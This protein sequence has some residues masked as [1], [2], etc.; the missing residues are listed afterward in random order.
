MLP[1]PLRHLPL[2]A[3]ALALGACGENPADKLLGGGAPPPAPTAP[4]LVVPASGAYTGA[5]IAGDEEAVTEDNVSLENI[6]EFESGV[7]KH[8]AIIAFS[9][10][11]GEQSFPAE[12]IH[13][14]SAHGSVP[15]IFWSPWDR[16]YLETKGPDRFRLDAILAGRWDDYI[17]RWADAAREHG[18]PLLVSF[19]NEMNGNWFPWSGSLYGAGEKLET[20]AG[21]YAGP[22]LFKQT[23]R[24]VVDRVRA[25]GAHNVQWVF[26]L[27]NFS[28]PVEP[29]NT[30]ANYYPGK[31]YVD[32][33]GLSVYGQQFPDGEWKDFDSMLKPGYDELAKV[34]PDKPMMVTEWGVGEFPRR[35]NAKRSGGDKARW[36]AE[37]FETMRLEFPRIRAAIYW[38]ERWQNSAGASAGF[39]SNLR[40]NSSPAAL[41]AYR[42]GIAVPF[43]LGEP[44]LR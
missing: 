37:A 7:G 15:L 6:E 4:K 24:R 17:D 5:F 27:N 23:Y 42:E 18:G 8:Q 35:D 38:H 43:W 16:P 28:E 32:W 3:F 20:P 34:D 13:I 30:F 25:R 36:I 12:A 40:V 29:W 26:H 2:L 31:D 11:W 9:S 14:V 41:K 21:G 19:C 33:M 39:Y 22:E 10:Y 1:F 44:V